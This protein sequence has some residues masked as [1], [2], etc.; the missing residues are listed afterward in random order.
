MKQSQS[1]TCKLDLQ[2][3]YIH[4][5]LEM[6]HVL[7]AKILILSKKEAAFKLIENIKLKLAMV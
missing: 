4:S 2:K 5:Q 7:K 3:S 6:K 1:P